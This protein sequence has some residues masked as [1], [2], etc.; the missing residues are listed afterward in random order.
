MSGDNPGGSFSPVVLH[1]YL[2]HCMAADWCGDLIT[3]LLFR[4]SI[5]QTSML[6]YCF[7]SDGTENAVVSQELKNQ[8]RRA[9]AFCDIHPLK[10]CAARDES[11]KQVLL[12]KLGKVNE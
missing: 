4:N 12:V 5:F 1:K 10:S 11:T 6:I 2:P 7:L 8:S 9:F 3:C